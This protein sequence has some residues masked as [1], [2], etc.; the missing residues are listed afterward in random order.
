MNTTLTSI[1][2]LR[3]TAPSERLQ[4]LASLEKKTKKQADLADLGTVMR[5]EGS[6][7]P[8]LIAAFA[9]WLDEVSFIWDKDLRNDA[10]DD[11]RKTASALSVDYDTVYRTRIHSEDIKQWMEKNLIP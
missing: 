11:L 10:L 3:S 7:N 5:V 9:V 1:I 4:V 8:I 6:R 2:N